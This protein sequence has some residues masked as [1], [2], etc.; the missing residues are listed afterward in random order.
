VIVIALT[1][2][3]TKTEAIVGAA[4]DLKRRRG[5]SAVERATDFISHVADEV[6]NYVIEPNVFADSFNSPGIDAP[7]DSR[8]IKFISRALLEIYILNVGCF[9]VFVWHAAL[10]V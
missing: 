6:G 7:Y 4:I 2:G 1:C 10:C 5:V 9:G 8:P 3:A